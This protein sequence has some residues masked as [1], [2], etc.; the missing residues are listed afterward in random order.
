MLNPYPHQ[1]WLIIHYTLHNQ[2]QGNF[3][4][5]ASIFIQEIVKMHHVNWLSFCDG[6]NVS[7]WIAL[8]ETFTL[9]YSSL[10]HF[11]AWVAV[12]CQSGIAFTSGHANSSSS[13]AVSSNPWKQQRTIQTSYNFV[14]A[15]FLPCT[16][17]YVSKMYNRH[18]IVWDVF[19]WFLYHIHQ[20]NYD[21][22]ILR[23]VVKDKITK[24]SRSRQH[25]NHQH[26]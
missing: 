13:L 6:L 1:R 16:M 11:L 17:Q 19:Q 18:P 15:N 7:T 9:L 22:I 8:C 4:K 2:F 26:P 10:L 14:T 3:N 12:I 25:Q 23:L 21:D 24:R 20:Q 5:Y